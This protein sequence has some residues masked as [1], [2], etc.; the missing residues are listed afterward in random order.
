MYLYACTCMYTDSSLPQI[1]GDWKVFERNIFERYHDDLC[2]A[3]K[4]II[5]LYTKLRTNL[6]NVKY[7]L[8]IYDF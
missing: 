5:Y 1:G 3:L 2:Y 8:F 7:L 6:I 4:Y